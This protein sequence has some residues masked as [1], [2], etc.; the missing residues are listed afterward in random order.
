MLN[1]NLLLENTLK[2]VSTST[3]DHVDLFFTSE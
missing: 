3:D 2:K 1:K